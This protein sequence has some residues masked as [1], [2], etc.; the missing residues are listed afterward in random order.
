MGIQLPLPENAHGI[1][2]SAS[3][4][5]MIH[6]LKFENRVLPGDWSVDGQTEQ[7][8][9]MGNEELSKGYLGERREGEYIR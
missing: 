7:F 8:K 2:L 4:A 6:C 9:V 5:I 3:L 1:D